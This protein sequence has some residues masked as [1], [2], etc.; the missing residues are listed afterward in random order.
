MH[1]HGWFHGLLACWLVGISC[2]APVWAERKQGNTSKTDVIYQP[3]G[4]QG[5]ITLMEGDTRLI[6]IPNRIK[7]VDGFDELLV[8][9]LAIQGVANQVRVTGLAPGATKV[10]LKDE[11]DQYYT[12]EVYVTGDTRQLESVIRNAF[13]EASVT[14]VKVKDAVLLTGWVNQQDQLTPIVSIAE[15]YFPK[16]LNYMKVGGV[17][18][19]MLRVKIMEVQRSRIRS[20]GFNFLQ[21]S[22]HGYVH[23]LP[24]ALAPLAGSASASPIAVPFAGSSSGG[25]STPGFNNSTMSFGIAG[26]NSYFNGFLEALKEERLLKVLAEPNLVTVNGRQADF[27]SGGSF[28]VPVP[29]SLGTVTIQWRDFGVKLSFV[30]YVLGAGRLRLDVQPEVSDQDPATGVTLNGTT[31]NGLSTR[32]V[33][34]QVEMNFGQT[35]MIAGLL[36]TRTRS[37]TAKVPF[38]GELPWIGAA[39]RRVKEDNSETELLVMV[40]PDLVAPLDA[41]QVPME[42]PGSSTTQPTDKELIINGQI[43]VPNYGP[44]CPNC[45]TPGAANYPGIIPLSPTPDSNMPLRQPYDTTNP[46]GTEGVPIPPIPGDEA[47][48]RT[49]PS[50]NAQVRVSTKPS[51]L[52]N[53]STSETTANARVQQ[54]GGS[55][56]QIDSQIQ[57][58]SY[59]VPQTPA[60]TRP[61]PT[62]KRTT[63]PGLIAP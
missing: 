1:R 18:Q 59:T 41:E 5:E 60:T 49:S 45:P 10:I 25:I 23:S 22:E 7:S 17:Q 24:G 15:Q 28:P 31:V 16:V 48:N 8:K 33:E 50:G 56:A 46:A 38:F 19:V 27:L 26:G 40:T 20:F 55:T 57:Q 42:Y 54:V 39:F 58:S 34:T 4:A 51:Y 63:R 2:C 44:D 12:I 53:R 6:Q 36:N 32:R 61:S 13:P 35:L 43:E 37:A 3:A 9:V 47:R 11:S 21:L 30:P 62:K 29:Q 14:A 52:T